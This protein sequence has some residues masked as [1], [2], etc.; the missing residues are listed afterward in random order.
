M[1]KERPIIFNGEMVRAILDGRKTQTRR[2]IKPHKEIVQSDFPDHWMI[3][4]GQYVYWPFDKAELLPLV[5]PYGQI[6][7]RLWVRETFAEK[8]DEGLGHNFVVYKA[9]GPNLKSGYE[10]GFLAQKWTPS[11]FMPRWASRIT[12][13]ITDIRVELLQAIRIPE[14]II[15]E[16]LVT[17][18]REFAAIH[19]LSEQFVSLWDSINAKRGFSWDSN[20]WVWVVNF[21]R[22]DP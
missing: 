10:L 7:D 8:I 2:V 6:G 16:G 13:E 15:A 11:I 5:C 12:L 17:N 20:P 1:N 14:D 21:Q 9:D 4:E 18:L 19:H 3:M 22:L